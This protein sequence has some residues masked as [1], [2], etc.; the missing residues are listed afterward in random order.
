[1]TSVQQDGSRN[2]GIVAAGREVD[3]A[4][5]HRRQQLHADGVR[6]CLSAYVDVHGVPKAKA[7]PIEHFARMMGGS[8]LFT[9]AAIDGLGQAPG[10]RRAV[11]AA[12]PRRAHDP[13]VAADVAWAPGYLHLHGEPYPMCS[14]DGAAGA[15]S[16]AAAERGYSFNLGIETEFFLVQRGENGIAPANPR[17]LLPRAAYDVAELLEALPILRELIGYMNE[18]GWDVALV[19]PRGREQPVR[20]RLLVHGRAD[21]GRPLRA[22]A[23]DDEA[24]RAPARR[25]GDVHAEA[26]R[27][28]D[29]ERRRTSTCRSPTARAGANLFETGRRPARR[30]RVGARLQLHRR[31]ARA[32]ASDLRRR[33]PDGELVQ[34]ARE[35]RLD[36]RVHVG[37]GVHL[38]R[39]QQ[40]HAHAPHPDRLAT[41]RV[42]RGRHVLQPL[43]R[44]RDVPRP[45]GSRGSSSG[46]TPA[47][48]SRSTCTSRATP[49]STSYKF[50][51][52]RGRCSRRS[53]RSTPTRLRPTCS[54]PELKAS[55]VELKS[56]N[57][58]ST[59]TRS[60]RG[61]TTV[62]RLSS[63]RTGWSWT[64]R[65]P[66]PAVRARLARRR[67]LGRP[68][69]LRGRQAVIFCFA[70]W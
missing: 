9:G 58:G 50:R 17:D 35:E 13:A 53:R 63:S 66:V 49:S 39:P 61:S 62:P 65:A 2:A 27:R 56:A 23:A 25:A 57:G 42:A 30:R 48:R 52:S 69:A 33:L 37:A 22:L 16:T 31:R 60:R 21:D 6:Y 41:C 20:V 36:D 3:E 4:W 1:M 68:T 14:R 59:T 24:R 12:R 28:P 29:R 34:A 10:R 67:A 43:P 18:L 11:A 70:S 55:F 32:R 51:H 46:S 5:D 19:R 54:G 26:L 7:V 40:P 64:R 8:E 47:T 45:P 38:V 44:G 15:S